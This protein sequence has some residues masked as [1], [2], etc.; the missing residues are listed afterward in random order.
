MYQKHI[1][2]ARIY[3]KKIK[4]TFFS[5]NTRTQAP[6]ALF[7]VTMG[8]YSGPILTSTNFPRIRIISF[9]IEQFTWFFQ[10]M[11]VRDNH[12]QIKT[13]NKPPP[14]S[15]IYILPLFWF[16]ML[17]LEWKM[18]TSSNL[19]SL[20]T[21]IFREKNIFLENSSYYLSENIYFSYV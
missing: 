1:F 2:S 17:F 16:K 13:S 21:S 8:H 12:Y 18:M 11:K 14:S 19:R 3:L 4:L 9:L 10:H 6:M 20:G 5:T 15:L 7:L